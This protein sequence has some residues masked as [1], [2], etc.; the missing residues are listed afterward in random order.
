MKKNIILIFLLVLSGTVYSQK[1][2]ETVAP[3]LDNFDR[4]P[5][6]QAKDGTILILIKNTGK[7]ADDCIEK[8]KQQAVYT[9]IF[10]GYSAANNI[11]AASALSPN[12]VSLYNE[13]IDFF[14]EFFSNTTLY[15][16]YVPKGALD[17]KNP[18]SEIDRK[19]VECTVIV[20]IE[21]NRLRTDL[22]KQNIIKSLADFGFTPTVFVVPSDEWMNKHGFVTKKDNQGTVDEIYDYPNAIINP[23]ISKA[24]SAIENK[25]NKPKGPFKICDM[26][27]KLDQIKLE[28]AKNNARSKAKQESS[29]DIF[30]RV[31]A[32]DLWVKVD[33]DEKPLNGMETQL[34]VTLT[35]I[36]PYTNN[37]VLAGAT[38]E[39]TTH[40][41][42]K[43]ELMSNA[44]NGA[45]DELRTLIF[46]YFQDKVTTGQEGTLTFSL[47]ENADFNFDTP[48]P[49]GAESKE[50]NRIIAK[51][52]KKFCNE[53]E[54]TIGTETTRVITAKIP[55][56]YEEDGEKEKNTFKA[57]AY[58]I[59][60]EM[61][62]IGFA[63]TAEP[64][65]LGRV[66]IIITGKK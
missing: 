20:T 5:Y 16:S 65:G 1:K 45:S 51:I 55:L 50:L 3:W 29:L 39:K 43:F 54:E 18:V 36:D 52:V 37:K 34:L 24:L 35:G 33:V 27:S 4:S 9:V 7:D 11:P 28:E 17:P 23:E 19:T 53:R 30:A 66:E 63:C 26:K 60:D 2:G 14:K 62:K 42:N 56:F 49:S 47:G 15:R 46:G 32:A 21:I 31:L 38:V 48:F 10:S 6:Q 22:E 61:S 64:S 57:F 13:K 59:T 40:G 41:A 25:Y 44:I 12:G 58:K 8:A